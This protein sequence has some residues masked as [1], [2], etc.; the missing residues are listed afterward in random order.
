MKASRGVADWPLARPISRSCMKR[1]PGHP[2]P[3]RLDQGHQSDLR[4]GFNGH[5]CRAAAAHGSGVVPPGAPSWVTPELIAET[6]RVWQPYYGTP[7]TP[8]D[9]LE[10]IMNVGQLFDVLYEDKS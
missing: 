6:L 2:E 3:T 10:M 5:V 1:I 8:E 4:P 9:A 7:L